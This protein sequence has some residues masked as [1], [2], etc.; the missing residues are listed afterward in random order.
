[1]SK[2]LVFT[3]VKL[4]PFTFLWFDGLFQFQVVGTLNTRLYTPCLEIDAMNT[5]NILSFSTIGLQEA[6]YFGLFACFS[7]K[8][9]THTEEKHCT[10]VALHEAIAVSLRFLSSLS[11]KH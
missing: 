1:M 10:W 2:L 11:I 5:M 3:C 8:K 9:H 6:K 4:L 7:L